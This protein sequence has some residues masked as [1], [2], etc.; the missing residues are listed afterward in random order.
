MTGRTEVGE[1]NN[2]SSSK[3]V[4]KLVFGNVDLPC[5]TA[6]FKPVCN[7]IKTVILSCASCR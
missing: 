4:T 7:N 5:S 6:N 3:K 2:S 1:K